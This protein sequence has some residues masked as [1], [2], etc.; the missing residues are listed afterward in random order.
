MP[1]ST[2]KSKFLKSKSIY[3]KSV[4]KEEK[5]NLLLRNMTSLIC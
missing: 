1:T 5:V 4:I 3:L 2:R